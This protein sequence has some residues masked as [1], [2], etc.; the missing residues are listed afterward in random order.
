MP[1]YR[2]HGKRGAMSNSTPAR[3]SRPIF[4]RFAEGSFAAGC[5]GGG[6]APW[7]AERRWVANSWVAG[8]SCLWLTRSP[9]NVKLR[10]APF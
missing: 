3:T 8:S 6:G 10:F 2:F 4:H 7:P 5:L 9:W 1:K